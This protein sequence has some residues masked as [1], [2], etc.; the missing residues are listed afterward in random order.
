MKKI[1]FKYLIICLFIGI[2]NSFCQIIYHDLN[3]DVAFPIGSPLPTYSYTLDIDGDGTNDYRIRQDGPPGGTIYWNI[4]CFNGNTIVSLGIFV[5]TLVYGSNISSGSIFSG[6]STLC[7]LSNP[8]PWYNLKNHFIGICF[9]SP[10]GLKYGW[11]RLKNIMTISDYAYNSASNQTIFAGEGMPYIDQ[12]LQIQDV[13]NFGNGTD[14][15][16]K[17]NKIFYETMISAYKVIIVPNSN[18]STFNL[19][20]AKQVL[21]SNSL[22]ISPMNKNI[23]TILNSSSKDVYGNLITSLKPYNAF[24]VSLP[25]LSNTFDTLISYVS[26][27]LTLE[28]PNLPAHIVNI[29]STKIPGSY[30][31]LN[32]SFNPPVTENSI[33]N[34][35]LFFI[36]ASDSVNFNIDRANLVTAANYIVIA[37]TGS[38]QN[39]NVQSNQARTH[40]GNLLKPFMKYKAVLMSVTD[41]ITTNT[42]VLSNISNSFTVYTQVQPV[43][44]IIMSDIA[45]NHNISDINAYFPKVSNESNI[46]GYRGF[47][48][49]QNSLATFNL[50]SAN[51]NINYVTFNKNG[52][53][54]NAQLLNS[55]NDIHGIP[56]QESVIYHFFVLTVNDNNF[57]D[58][59]ALSSVNKYFLFNTPSS[60]N[61]GSPDTLVAKYYDISDT[62]A[63]CIRNGSFRDYYM[64]MDNNGSND[65]YFHILYNGSPA[66]RDYD[67]GVYPLNQTEFSFSTPT[68]TIVLANDSADMIYS[69]LNWGSV[70]GVLSH[71]YAFY[72]SSIYDSY[73]Q[74]KFYSTKYLAVR[75][76]NTD[77]I[78]GWVKAKI[79]YSGGPN[80]S[81]ILTIYSY[82][83]QK[84]SQLN[85]MKE[86]SLNSSDVVLYPNPAEKYSVIRINNFSN[87]KYIVEVSDMKGR[88]IFTD[89]IISNDYKLNTSEI[90]KGIYVV[91][92][93]ADNGSNQVLKLIVQ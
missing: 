16:V 58:V 12:N 6:S 5:D 89:K 29:T 7:S 43:T 22:L 25:N 20:S 55:M 49:P 66:G 30:Y 2:T 75:L 62:T 17:F 67:V 68:S 60:L 81:I 40:N 65:L 13:S 91:K 1:D 8:N 85:G 10:T 28:N 3:P 42:S 61:V 78:Y 11:I 31:N 87:R 70:H 33:L 71:E 83:L 54:Q 41:T 21:N 59:N 50:D 9:N 44:E 34:Y 84:E 82:G 39:I 93:I 48:V 46:S 18:L 24:V 80:N 4:D 73:G 19:D 51:A 27:K 63:E 45:D 79:S 52:Q 76:I 35:R 57:S 26:N 69:G 53:N 14:M 32:L 47:V 36:Q 74:W 86:N 38:S 64:D 56:V 77:T 90:A 37:K 23:D 92:I 72:P 88:L 15:R